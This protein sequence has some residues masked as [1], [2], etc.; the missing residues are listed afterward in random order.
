MTCCAAA[1][2]TLCPSYC[3]I[4]MCARICFFIGLCL[5]SWGCWGAEEGAFLWG[6]VVRNLEGR[7]MSVYSTLFEA[8]VN[9]D[10]MYVPFI[11]TPLRRCI[12]LLC[13][14]CNRS[15][16]HKPS[17][18]VPTDEEAFQYQELL[19][20]PFAVQMSAHIIGGSTCVLPYDPNLPCSN[21][22]HHLTT[23]Y[24]S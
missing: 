22:T 24:A 8:H 17:L 19:S 18:T 6:R 15:W 16:W 12:A 11:T 1:R 5:R 3:T 14:S 10:I 13:A 23:L 21:T 2:W 7:C 4:W 20:S 9:H